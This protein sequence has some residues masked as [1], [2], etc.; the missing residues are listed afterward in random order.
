M[1]NYFLVQINVGL[2]VRVYK[3][4]VFSQAI[5]W[6]FYSNIRV[7]FYKKRISFRNETLVLG[8][9]ELVGV[10]DAQQLAHYPLCTTESKFAPI[11]EFVFCE[12]CIL[13]DDVFCTNGVWDIHTYTHYGRVYTQQDTGTSSLCRIKI[14][15]VCVWQIMS[16]DLRLLNRI[17]DRTHMWYS[18]MHPDWIC[19]N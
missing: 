19:R 1:Q 5:K 15:V 6:L 18:E 12:Q 3:L 14:T 8:R 13:V 16:P 17:V 7:F 9:G 2:V 11:K 4:F 10:C